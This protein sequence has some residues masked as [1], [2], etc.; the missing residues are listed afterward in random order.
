MAATNGQSGQRPLYVKLARRMLIAVAVLALCLVPSVVLYAITGE[1]AATWA[2]VA[3]IAGV[4][5]VVSGGREVAIFTC[6]VMAII[7]PVAIVAGSVPIAGAALMALMCLMVGYMARFG[8]N[9]ATLLVPVF[10]AWLII[11]PPV[12][13]PQ[14]LVDRTDGTYL[15]WMSVIFLVGA[16]VPTLVMMV[17]LRK[18]HRPAPTP[19]PRKVTIPYTVTI[20]VL[21]TV[22]TFWLLQ[23]PKQIGGAWVIATILVLAQVGDVGTVRRTIQRV[24]GTLL[25]MIIVTVIVVEV[26]SLVVVY[27]I[28]LVLGI[29]ALTAKFSPRYW[30][31]MTL[32]T[33]TV[34]CLGSASSSQVGT[35]ADQR[36]VDT[37]AGGGLVLIAAALTIGY[38]HLAKRLGIAPTIEDPL[39][40][41]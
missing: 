17:A 25:G 29:A 6:V 9:R 37:L 23:H 3:G 31:Y 39:P 27:V 13:G 11:A 4:A 34:V 38:A 32:I 20:T 22:A 30:L 19:H 36:L 41:A 28:G 2:T 26:N 40:L 18:V 12:W 21:T 1:A 8:L 5:A 7:T 35:L 24:A 14:H 10:M 15:V 33:P 16:L